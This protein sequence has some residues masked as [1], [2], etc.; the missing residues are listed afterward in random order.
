MLN[1]EYELYNKIVKYS[2][3]NA[4]STLGENVRY[5]MYKYNLTLD[6]WNQNINNI[7]KKVD[8]YVNNHAD[9]AVECVA[10]AIRELC[11]MRD[12]DDTRPGKKRYTYYVHV[13]EDNVKVCTSLSLSYT[14]IACNSAMCIIC[15]HLCKYI[16]PDR[17]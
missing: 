7:Y 14:Q 13:S 15:N 11:D 3:H 12:S 2:M 17:R 1:S 10:I 8:M 4:N 5:F 9:R 6:D 16:S